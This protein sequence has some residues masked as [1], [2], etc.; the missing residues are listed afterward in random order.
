MTVWL[1]V[2]LVKGIGLRRG[3]DRQSKKKKT[4]PLKLSA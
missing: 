1:F 3:L 2:N 4:P